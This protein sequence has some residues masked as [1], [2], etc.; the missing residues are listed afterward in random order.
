LRFPRGGG[1]RSSGLTAVAELEAAVKTAV[2]ELE[3]VVKTAVAGGFNMLTP[4][5]RQGKA[6]FPDGN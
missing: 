2:A 6:V 1:G 3:A 5:R 4:E